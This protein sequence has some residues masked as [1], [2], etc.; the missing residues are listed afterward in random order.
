MFAR[1]CAAVTVSTAAASAI[2]LKAGKV[3]NVKLK[4]PNVLLP[5]A[6]GMGSA[7]KVLVFVKLAGLENIAKK[8]STVRFRD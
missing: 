2:A 5:I 8:V 7:E 6:M 4:L 1:Y 3:P